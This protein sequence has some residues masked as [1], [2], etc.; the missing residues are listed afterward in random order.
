MDKKEKINENRMK[1]A[2]KIFKALD[3]MY[4]CCGELFCEIRT[5]DKTLKP[6]C[7][8]EGHSI[9]FDREVKRIIYETLKI[10]GK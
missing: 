8:E 9:S 5:S 2:E 4:G 1:K 7:I 6:I 10:A 3:A